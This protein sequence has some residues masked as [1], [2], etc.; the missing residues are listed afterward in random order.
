MA[1]KCEYEGWAILELFGHQRGSGASIFKLHQ[2]PHLTMLER[3]RI[4]VLARVP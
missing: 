3:G 2:C 1:E 4:V